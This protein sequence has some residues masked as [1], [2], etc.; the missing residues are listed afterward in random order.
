MP[1][2]STLEDADSGL[3]QNVPADS[4]LP[5][6]VPANSGLPQDLPADSSLPQDLPMAV[7]AKGPHKDPNKAP[8]APDQPPA[9]KMKKTTTVCA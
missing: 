3:P 7:D 9:K 6:I 1:E 2:D 4:G 8:E 5:Q